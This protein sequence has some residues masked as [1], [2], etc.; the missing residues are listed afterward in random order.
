MNAPDRSS[1]PAL[2]KHASS[3]WGTET[4]ICDH[5]D[6]PAAHLTWNELHS[7][8]RTFAAALLRHGVTHGDR[9]AIW[10]PNTYHW[11]VSALGSQYI[12][13][14]VVPISTRYTANEAS[15]IIS[16]SQ[17]KALV[18]VGNFL[19]ADR[20]GDLLALADS[21]ATSLHRVR[22]I[23]Q[24]PY[25]H[26][27]TNGRVLTWHDFLDQ[28]TSA[29]LADAEAASDTVVPE[30]ISDILF[31]SG[32]TG[33]SKG[34]LASHRQSVEVGRLWGEVATLD[35]S[36]RHLILSPFFHTFGYKAG[37]LACM[38]YGTTMVPWSVFDPEEVIGLVEAERISV[39][40]GA[41]TIFQSLLDHPA[42]AGRNID[43][44]RVAVTG[45]TTVPVTL[46]ERMQ[47]ELTFDTVLTAYGLTETCGYVTST[48]VGDAPETVA[49]TCG[50][51][52]DGMEV[53]LSP[54]GE[55][56]V[57]GR[58]VMHGYLDDPAATATA[59]D[60]DGWLHTG[61]IASIDA[62]GNI[63]ITDRLKDMYITGGFN[64]YPAEVEQVIARIPGV[65][66]C[67]VIGAAD[68]RLGEVGH[69]FITVR[70]GTSLSGNAV[71]EQCS[72]VLAK[73]KVPRR[74]TIVDE[75]PRNASGKIDKVELR[76]RV[77]HHRVDNSVV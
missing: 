35:N 72:A 77:G 12:G 23:V 75:L 10:A 39:L 33:R 71:T 65:T 64:V 18:V 53:K 62:Q 22:L 5:Q 44:L 47:T 3:R 9:V 15:D 68:D 4:A 69:A 41:P 31:T 16:R 63:A 19:G 56:L 20:L 13:A 38:H 2:L 40:T 48:R 67:A 8:V 54:D 32:T 46:V 51:P 45:A 24:I 14:V 59:I 28:A 57:R 50:R 27:V 6:R 34:V 52:V 29:L 76:A 26:P 42:L 60:K 1:T 17:A 43:S 55:L 70:E 73:F 61:D 36:D 7:L 25:N 30:D 37:F 58:L 21:R 49:T 74:V 66:G 11:I